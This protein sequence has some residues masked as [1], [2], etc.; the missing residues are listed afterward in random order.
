MI[1]ETFKHNLVSNLILFLV[2]NLEG[3]HNPLHFKVEISSSTYPNEEINC[4]IIVY[5]SVVPSS[6][7]I[8]KGATNDKSLI[9]SILLI[10]SS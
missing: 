10:H 6:V 9:R 1:E 2:N 5:D 8:D 3:D 4:N 7:K